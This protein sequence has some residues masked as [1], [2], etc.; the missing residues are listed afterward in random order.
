MKIQI[1]T[2]TALLALLVSGTASAGTLKTLSVINTSSDALAVGGNVNATDTAWGA[3]NSTD[4]MNA[5][6]AGS[7][8]IYSCDCF[9]TISVI[10]TSNGATAIGGGIAG[11]VVVADG[12]VHEY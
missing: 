2:A 9:D 10:N 5:S 11:S 3:A 6:L 7:V 12:M 1:L 4:A 8:D